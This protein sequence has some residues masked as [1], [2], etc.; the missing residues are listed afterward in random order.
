MDLLQNVVTRFR[1]GTGAN[2]GQ[3]ALVKFATLSTLS[4]DLDDHH[5]NATCGYPPYTLFVAIHD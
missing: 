2:D 4:F 5:S 1:V 3:I